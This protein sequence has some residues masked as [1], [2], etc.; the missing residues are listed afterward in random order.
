M[1]KFQPRPGFVVQAYKYALDPTPRQ[2]RDLARH[3]GAARKAYNWA[4]TRIN[5]NWAQRKAEQS[6]GIPDDQATEWVK[7]SLP[8][9]RKAWNQVKSEVAPW[10]R[11][12]SKEAYNTGLANASAAFTNYTASKNGTR[13]GRRV[14]RPHRKRKGNAAPS[15]R[16]AT[17][18]IR[19]EPD[20]HHVTL[21]R[22]GLIK[23]HESTR[24]LGRRIEQDTA[25]ILSATVRLEAGRWSVS[26]H[27]EVRRTDP[28]PTR[29]RA[30]VGVDL[31]INH[32]AVLSE[33]VPGVSDQD[34]FV[35][36]PQH[37]TG[38][39]CALRR[40]SR[41]VSRR[42]GPDRRTGQK[43]SNR[44]R[45][46]NRERNKIHRRVV[47][48]RR[49]GLHKLT[50]GLAIA[51]G[52]VVIEDLNV[53]GMLRNRCL[54]RAIADAGFGEIRRQLTYKTTWRGGDLRVADR[55][56]PSS[57]TCS[58]C[59]T[60]KPKLPLRVRVFHCDGC[61][62]VLDRD[63]NAARNLASL[64][65]ACTAGTGVAGDLTPRSVNGRGADR[66]TPPGGAGGSETS[67][68]TTFDGDRPLVTAGPQVMH[69]PKFTHFAT[70]TC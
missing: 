59:G 36:N 45:K 67:T 41:R 1:R 64:V 31:G 53:A 32:L 40:A 28:A 17:G 60:V 23:T 30:V 44:W 4:V 35:A 3:C 29:P 27:C 52:T 56:F 37:L 13:A 48:L 70:G 65:V 54:A 55:W 42:C 14:G 16:F 57:K 8:A 66:K 63:V 62:L 61:D 26:F 2:Q 12:C 11:E 46:A 39:Q 34:G 7:W 10:W 38:A 47:N 9:L 33:P 6:Y 22:L 49:D 50:T 43:P 51:T 58:A 18:A 19:V 21:P 24:K 5:A 15:C 68:P 69:S 25:R 20:R